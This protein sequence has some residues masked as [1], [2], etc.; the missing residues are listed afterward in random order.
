MHGHPTRGVLPRHVVLGIALGVM[1]VLFAAHAHAQQNPDVKACAEKQGDEAI[2]ACTRAIESKDPKIRLDHVYFNRAV[3]WSGQ[4]KHDF[5]ILDYG[6]ALKINPKYA[7][8]YNYRG[9]AY[10][11]KS[12]WKLALADYNEA[13]KV[14]PKEGRYYRNRANTHRDLRDYSSALA[15]YNEASRLDP[16]DAGAI[17]G[18]AWVL[19]TAPDAKLRDA[20]RA[21]ALA[22]K[23]CEMTQ[24]KKGSYVDTLAAAYAEDG[25]FAEAVR[26]QEQALADAEF[27]KSEGT[28]ARARLKAYRERRPIR[29]KM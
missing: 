11:R 24:W 29:L 6:R 13:I 5:A 9:N 1:G 3:E 14:N 18:A 20:K 25:N 22:T 7:E 26:R 8:A 2:V 15:D 17:D 27:E 28:S 10:R 23:A 16:K 19:A 21:I 12:E 4:G